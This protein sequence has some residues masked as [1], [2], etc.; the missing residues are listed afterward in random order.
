M[1]FHFLF[2]SGPAAI[3]ILIAL[4]LPAVQAARE[5]AR[6]N[7]SS[8]NLKQIILAL[9]NYEDAKHHFPAR[10]NFDA[11]GKPLLS[12]RVHILPFL[13]EEELYKQFHL[14]EPWDS[15]HNKKLIDKMPAVYQHPGFDSPSPG[16]IL[17][18]A[19]VGP[20]CAF[21]G[22]EGTTLQSFTD[23]TSQTIVVVEA[24]KSK[25]VPWTK[26]EDWQM[27]PK[28]PLNGLGGIFAGGVFNAVFAD[29]H[30]DGI[31][32]SIDP[33]IF[34]ALLTRNGGEAIG[35]GY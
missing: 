1:Q 25:A 30:V 21:E 35:P 10:A 28:N 32:E 34:R 8:N 4:L 24:A 33:A 17:Y 15:D 23:G 18:Q 20:G 6:R 31:S 29:G 3:G 26:P 27:D 13:E 2:P 9:L 11:A 14:D 22:N 19:V 7:Q 5:A 12:W 16:L